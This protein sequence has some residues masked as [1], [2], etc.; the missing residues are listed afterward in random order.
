MTKV[1]P[2]C[3]DSP[4]PQHEELSPSERYAASRRRAEHAKTELGKFSTT[5]EFPM[6]EFQYEASQYLEEG[7]A[8]LV[9]APTGAGKTVVAEFAIHLRSEERRVGKECR[10]LGGRDR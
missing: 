6:D 2:M 5:L 9:A 4:D 3:A 10:T 1:A 7:H 8:V